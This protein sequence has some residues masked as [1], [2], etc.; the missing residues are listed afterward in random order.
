MAAAL[1]T[2]PFSLGRWFAHLSVYQSHLE[3][4]QSPILLDLSP[5]SVL[6]EMWRLALLQVSGPHWDPPS[7]QWLHSQRCG[8]PLAAV[9]WTWGASGRGA[10]ARALNWSLK[11][12]VLHCTC[13]LV[14]CVTLGKPQ[15]FSMPVAA[16]K[17]QGC[18]EVGDCYS[19]CFWNSEL[20]CHSCP[21]PSLPNLQARE[22]PQHPTPKHPSAHFCPQSLWAW[23]VHLLGSLFLQPA[24][25]MEPKEWNWCL[26]V[27]DPHLPLGGMC[28]LRVLFQM[29]FSTE[30]RIQN[31]RASLLQV[32]SDV[33]DLLCYLG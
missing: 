4:L 1:G 22:A 9:H 14:S 15:H 30:I 13:A 28:V 18:D 2:L 20:V 11:A 24:L 29:P 6:G 12:R 17:A 31:P 33:N 25:C 26:P 7:R 16:S 21:Q 27:R 3:G 23:V 19:G 32:N 8:F 10:A 5:Q